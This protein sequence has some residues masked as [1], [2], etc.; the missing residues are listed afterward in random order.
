[1]TPTPRP[2]AP[3]T[4]TYSNDSLAPPGR[5]SRDGRTPSAASFATT[6]S[7]MRNGPA[8]G[9]FTSELKATIS[10]PDVPRYEVG[11]F[12]GMEDGGLPGHG[13]TEQRQADFRDKI[14]K[15]TKIKIGT[16]N[17]LEALNTKKE[18]HIREQRRVVESELNTSNRKIAQLKLDLNAEIQR[19]K[20]LP[21]SS[22]KERMSTQLFM[23]MSLNTTQSPSRPHISSPK[24]CKLWR[25][26]IYHPTI[27]STT[28]MN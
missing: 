7:F 8:P 28:R 2:Q 11:S 15:E 17:L 19:S 4:G 16:E 27:T 18:K 26:Q 25:Q 13:T 22:P 20:E 1:M 14:E 3:N 12:A 21:M 5:P 23:R 10:R 6:K 9:S 24:Y